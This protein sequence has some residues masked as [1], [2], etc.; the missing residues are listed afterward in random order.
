M[1]CNF[2]SNLKI[3]RDYDGLL[4][5]ALATRRQVV[6]Y[7]L[8]VSL[9]GSGI[10]AASTTGSKAAAFSTVAS[11]D[12]TKVAFE[13]RGSGPALVLIGGALNDRTMATPL[14][15]L[16]KGDFTV[17][18]YDRRGRGDSTDTVPYAVKREVEDLAALI[19]KLAAPVLVFG[20]SSGAILAL[21]AAAAKLP[22]AR[23]AVYEPPFELD[24]KAAMQSAA[25]ADDVAAKLKDGAREEAVMF[26]LD[27]TGMPPAMITDV[28]KSP[29]W[30][31]F[32][33]VAPTLNYDLALVR[34]GGDSYVPAERIKTIVVPVLAMAGGESP[35]FMKQAA[36]AVAKAA[37]HGRYQ[38]IA[39]Q[40]HH[41][42][43]EIVA[44]LLKAYFK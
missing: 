1:T 23:L 44:P 13:R 2:A 9:T 24:A 33:S 28:K 17:Y 7:A 5:R 35:N 41:A 38:E 34:N 14:A 3:T 6:A 18:T 20:H 15:E 8:N 11:A 32:I 26:F 39:G 16:L 25:F 37:P 22:I 4:A 27:G 43:P 36:Q 10:L 29:M 21:E 30:P 19:G 31:I 42:P 12:G 40:T